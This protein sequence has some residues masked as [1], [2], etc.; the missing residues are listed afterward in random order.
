MYNLKALKV[1]NLRKTFRLQ[2]KEIEGSNNEQSEENPS[3]ESDCESDESPRNESQGHDQDISR[4]G[5]G[6]GDR[7][8]SSRNVIESFYQYLTSTDAGNRDIS[9]AT[10]CSGRVFNMLK[11]T[12]DNYSIHALIDTGL[13]HFLKTLLSRKNIYIPVPSKHISK[14]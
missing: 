5:R 9:S 12:Y 3:N 14:V 10:Q 13:V 11:A 7:E 6:L 4:E 2:I 8:S 1:K